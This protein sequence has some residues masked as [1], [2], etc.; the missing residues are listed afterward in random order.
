MPDNLFFGMPENA[1]NMVRLKMIVHLLKV[2][3]Y[4]HNQRI[5]ETTRHYAIPRNNSTVTS[6]N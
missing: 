1:V 4:Y 5:K 3:S 2:L 6:L